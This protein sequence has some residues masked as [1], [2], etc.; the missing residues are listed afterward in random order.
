M[1]G[2]WRMAPMGGPIALDLTPVFM[3]MDRMRL[4]DDEWQE[5]YDDL[6]VI[7]DAALAQIREN[8]ASR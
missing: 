7:S 6:R 3:R 2:Q 1:S 5:L 8:Q 4:P